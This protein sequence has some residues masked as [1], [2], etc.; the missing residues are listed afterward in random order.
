MTVPGGHGNLPTDSQIG[1]FPKFHHIPLPPTSHSLF[2]FLPTQGLFGF[3]HPISPHIK[4]MSAA[5][6]PAASTLQMS[7]S[8]MDSKKLEKEG[9]CH[10]LLRDYFFFLLYF[11]FIVLCDMMFCHFGR[12]CLHVCA[13]YF[14]PSDA[15]ALKPFAVAMTSPTGVIDFWDLPPTTP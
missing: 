14:R 15:T 3:V 6:A 9:S 1:K 2:L 4:A 7:S 13:L 11:C 5:V 12:V 10:A 8:P